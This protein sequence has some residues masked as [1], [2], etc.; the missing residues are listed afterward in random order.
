[1]SNL[2][3][4]GFPVRGEQDVNRVI[5]DI[6]PHLTQIPCPPHGYYFR[7]GDPSGAE[8][9]LQTNPA[10]E[11]IGFNPAFAGES[12]MPAGLTKRIERDTSP[13]DGAFHAWA[14]PSG[15]DFE[16]TGAF[17][18]V[19]DVPD[20]RA[21]EGLELPHGT[22]VQLS[23]FASNDLRV[24]AD[25]DEFAA[26]Q[27][28]DQD[29]AT[30]SFIPSGL[31]SFGGNGEPVPNEQP[32]AHCVLTGEIGE[33]ELRTNVFTEEKFYR[34]QVATRAGEV[35][36]VADPLLFETEPA[37]GAIV[38]GSFWLSGRLIADK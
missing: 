25:A 5:M 15:E 4:I 36:V 18:F 31:F 3:D 38:R 34:L 16:T 8:I 32:Q 33:T 14:D 10:Q 20:F 37:P 7:F 12:R 1:M 9:Y 21:L 27:N 23:A 19:F 2:S 30:R 6:L 35:D 28:G 26:A 11:I 29:A 22:Q 24:Y 17:P 13:L